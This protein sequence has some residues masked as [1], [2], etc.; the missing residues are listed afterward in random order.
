M[1]GVGLRIAL[2]ILLGWC[3]AWERDE[4][5]DSSGAADL[6]VVYNIHVDLVN[7]LE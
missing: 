5:S 2:R 4:D 1:V 7:R 3:L 6:E